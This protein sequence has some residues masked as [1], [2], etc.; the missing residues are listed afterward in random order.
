MKTLKLFG[1]SLFATLA[2]MTLSCSSD[3]DG[4]GGGGGGTP[5]TTSIKAKVDG[6]QY[7]TFSISGVSAGVATSTG[8]GSGRMITITGSNDMG[9]TTSFTINLIGIDATGEYEIGPDSDSVLSFMSGVSY[10]TS[11]CAGATGTVNITLLNEDGI[12]GTFS[13]TGKDDDNC[14]SSKTVSQGSFQGEFM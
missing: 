5:T 14:S 13:F 2:L 10:D 6:T 4:D 12:R 1:I 9:G 7:Q 8:S 11:D 3:S